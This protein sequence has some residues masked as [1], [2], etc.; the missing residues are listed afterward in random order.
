MV[1]MKKSVYNF[2]QWVDSRMEQVGIS[3]YRELETRS[4]FTNGAIGKRR[5][6]DKF[7]TVEMAEGMCQAL[8][9]SW[10]ELWMRAGF[11][12]ESQL[13]AAMADEQEILDIF[14]SLVGARRSTVLDMLR[15]LRA[16]PSTPAAPPRR[17][18]T[19]QDLP[20]EPLMSSESLERALDWW[21]EILS[22]APEVAQPMLV[23]LLHV[24]AEWYE[25]GRDV[26]QLMEDILGDESIVASIQRRIEQ[27][28]LEQGGT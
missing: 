7:P 19:I 10:C 3:S 2:W 23:H 5:N 16:R 21:S 15:G 6:T 14:R 11:T 18:L 28:Q 13:K 17:R 4:G 25:R 12:T 9:V 22:S 24:A 8:E 20:A 26:G 27:E 1:T